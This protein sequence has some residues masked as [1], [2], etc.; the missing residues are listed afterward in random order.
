[1]ES[2]EKAEGHTYIANR[3]V[4]HDGEEPHSTEIPSGFL[5]DTEI[6]MADGKVRNIR[7]IREGDRVM[8]YDP[9]TGKFVP[10]IVSKVFS[11]MATDYYLRI[12]SELGRLDVTPNHLILV[13]GTWIIAGKIE[14]GD[15]LLGEGG[16]EA[17]VKSIEEVDCRQG[18][19]VWVYNFDVADT[20]TYIAN[21]IVVHNK[22]KLMRTVGFGNHEPCV[23]EGSLGSSSN[24]DNFAGGVTVP[25]SI[26]GSGSIG[27]SG[28][29]I[30]V[31]NY[32]IP[33]SPILGVR[34]SD[35]GYRNGVIAFDNL[36][37]IEKKS[38]DFGGYPSESPIVRFESF[39]GSKQII[40]EKQ[41]M[42]STYLSVPL[43]K[44][45]TKIKEG[46]KITIRRVMIVAP[47][48]P[49]YGILSLE[50]IK[51]LYDIPYEKA[52]ESLGIGKG[53]DFAIKITDDHGRELLYYGKGTEHA[54]IITSF[55]R[56][57]MVYP[58]PD[59]GLEKMTRATLTVYIFR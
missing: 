26:V 25:G 10:G 22:L 30:S 53:Y 42:T 20:H 39:E 33:E 9:R 28:G 21:G 19:V 34:K 6:T 41:Y 1:M 51:K 24:N 35:M 29:I 48:I 45:V 38:I 37:G 57:I 4:V 32:S 27:G 5:E 46:D 2:K 8:T 58:D 44:Y 18:R 7:E 15:L 59:L 14:V 55:S 3:M 47:D 56:N 36:L 49:M 31:N 23:R 12:E 54:K 16:K 52:K 50:K 40:V 17:R 43:V 11:D 13:N